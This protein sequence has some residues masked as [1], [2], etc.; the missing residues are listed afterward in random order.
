[1]NNTTIITSVTENAP[2]V[3][4]MPLDRIVESKTTRAASLPT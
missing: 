4:E 2:L 3:Q 1:M